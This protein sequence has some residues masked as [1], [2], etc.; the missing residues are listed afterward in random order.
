MKKYEAFDTLVSLKCF[1]ALLFTLLFI[2]FLVVLVFVKCE[3]YKPKKEQNKIEEL[4]GR[5]EYDSLYN[6]VDYKIQKAKA[7]TII[8][9]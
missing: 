3:E 8:L 6:D 1:N 5:K 7:I 9:E 4:I 2:S